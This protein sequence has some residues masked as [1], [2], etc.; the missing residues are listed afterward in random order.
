MCNSCPGRFL[1]I[2][3]TCVVFYRSTITCDW[4]IRT[5][6]R[7][8]HR[9]ILLYYNN[10]HARLIHLNFIRNWLDCKDG[11]FF[12]D[13]KCVRVCVYMCG[14]SVRI[15]YYIRSCVTNDIS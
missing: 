3:I 9:N 4:P 14:Y 1:P 6:L 12:R 13:D 5:R 7:S 10:E 15:V 8:G 11:F 2:F